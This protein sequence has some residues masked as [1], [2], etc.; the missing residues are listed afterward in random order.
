MRN[1]RF[2]NIFLWLVIIAFLATIFIVWGVG[3]RS[4]E[5]Y[6]ARVNDRIISFNEVQ[7]RENA[8]P[9]EVRAS[10]GEGFRRWLVNE[11][12]NSELLLAEAKRIKIPVSDAEAINIIT[13]N[14]MFMT[15]GFFDVG[16]YQEILRFNG[17]TP[18]AYEEMI[19][20]EI[21]IDKFIRLIR[22]SVIVTDEEIYLEYLYQNT[23]LHASYFPVYSANYTGAVDLDEALLSEY[24]ARSQERYRI[25]P[26]VKLKYIAF[27][28]DSFEFEPNISDEAIRD[29]YTAMLTHFFVPEML[30]LS[31]IFIHV[32]NWQ[33]EAAVQRA[34]D[35]ANAAMDELRKN[36]NFA[37][38]ARQYSENELAQHGGY[39]GLITRP[40]W[41]LPQELQVIF[42]LRSGEIS[43]I[44]QIEDGYA[45]FKADNYTAPR[46]IAYDEIKD[47]IRAEL[48]TEAKTI[49]YR[50][51]LYS[52]Y[53]EM[54][55]AG[56]ITAY[57]Q[58]NPDRF[59]VFET[60]FISQN[61]PNSIFMQDN[62]IRLTLFAL[63]RT[64]ISPLMGLD[65]VTYIFEI[66]DRINSR[67]PLLDEVRDVAMENYRSDKAFEAA[68]NDVN[69]KVTAENMTKA[70]FNAVADEFNVKA[71]TMP[72]FARMG[73]NVAWFEQELMEMLFQSEPG[74]VL[75][76]PVPANRMI[77]V[78]RVDDLV[79]PADDGLAA[80]RFRIEM[81]LK[82]VK[83]EGALAG[84]IET[85]RNRH[86]VIIN[87]NFR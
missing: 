15:N 46:V 62:E 75:L 21:R 54:L 44:M 74:A 67:L 38:V 7:Q 77:Y 18:A 58:R 5:T 36:R 68:V 11:I 53:R 31:E 51:Y 27:D 29:R 72:V 56:N 9:S 60:D 40:E 84:V 65:D 39:I 81:Y 14:G 80:A 22:N 42:N 16:R 34:A 45:I 35:K 6:A 26:R 78:V 59:N 71:E 43:D 79:R 23:E 55:S 86:K 61:D 83:G 52:V 48:E 66:Y 12:V 2:L 73:D 32:A 69:S 64:D 17:F 19:K 3:E 63:G 76:Y 37:D 4:S 24:Y 28:W 41:E 82:N 70:G 85:L 47:E 10:M 50:T 25:P 1:K 30:E 13:Q 20:D 57:M 87:E 8:I 49:A 33:D